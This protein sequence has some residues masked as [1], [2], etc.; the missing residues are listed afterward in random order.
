MCKLQMLYQGGALTLLPDPGRDLLGKFHGPEAAAPESERVAAI[1]QMPRSGTARLRVLQRIA[2]CGDR[3][4]TDEENSIA[5]NMRLY[6][7]AP[8]RNELLNDGWIEDSGQTR[9]TTM[10][11]PATVWVLT[12]EAKRQVWRI[13]DAS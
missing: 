1:M 12:E 3:G 6:T 4:A 8:R 2:A 5:L 11:A 9:P 13:R 7:A 10:R